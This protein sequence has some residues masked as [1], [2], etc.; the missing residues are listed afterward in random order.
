MTRKH[1]NAVDYRDQPKMIAKLLNNALATGDTTVV[2]MTIGDLLRAHGMSE[3]ARRT[4]LDRRTL[5]KSF[6]G[7][8]MP[9][10]DRFLKT[11]AALEVELVVKPIER[12]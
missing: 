11:L 10:L 12:S 9:N 1:L 4:G 7:N 5:Y 2:I 3:F 8:V 6:G